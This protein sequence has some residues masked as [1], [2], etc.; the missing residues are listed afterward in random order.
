L[1]F[2]VAPRFRDTWL[3]RALLAGLLVA[4]G[5]AVNHARIRRLRAHRIALE[6]L[7]E[8][9]THELLLEKEGA[10]AARAE[11]ER[12][13]EIAERADNV[14]TEILQIAAH[15]LKTPLQTIL[16]FS[17]LAADECRPGSPAAEYTWQIANG[18]GRMLEI[19]G[20][21]LDMTALDEG[22]LVPS[23]APVD[24]G[25]V[26]AQVVASSRPAA[27]R[28]RQRINLLAEPVPGVLGDELHLAQVID[29]LVSNA[30][31]YSPAG[32]SIDVE[33]G[34]SGEAVS[35]AVRDEGP[36][37]TEEDLARVF[38]RFNRL[39]ARP[40]GDETSTGLGLYI[41]RRLVEL[42][43]GTVRAE[44]A[45]PGRGARFVVVLPALDATR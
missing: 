31:K 37:L 45:G 8:A 15:D 35:V 33:V 41:V 1:S 39:T 26:A 23:W 5:A 21:L 27:D 22:R 7:V 4:L 16:G 10:D 11:A 44:S 12:H 40:T 6:R 20:S 13:R 9:R 2:R 43:G 25:Q 29:N 14:K 3:F 30:I 42:H 28:K 36:G 24:L 18:A 32:A 34:R 17:E 19:V 38:G